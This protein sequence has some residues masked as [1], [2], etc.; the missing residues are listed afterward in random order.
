MLPTKTPGAAVVTVSRTQP[1]TKSTSGNVMVA[2][3]P[4]RSTRRP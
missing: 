2:E 3:K 1:V 4:R